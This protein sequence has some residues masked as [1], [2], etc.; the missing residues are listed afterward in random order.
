MRAAWRRRCAAGLLLWGARGQLCFFFFF[1]LCCAPVLCQA[2]TS[3]FLLLRANAR[4]TPQS[5]AY[6]ASDSPEDVKASPL[7]RA[8]RDKRVDMV[9]NLGPSKLSTNPRGN[10]LVRRTAVDHAIPLLT[11]IKLAALLADAL[12]RHSKTPMIG[13]QPQQL[14]E[15]YKSEKESEAWTSPT[16]FH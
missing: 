6:P 3:A 14:F 7:L 9:I 15:Y 16:E 11:N 12:E 8:I 2:H 5:L 13:L 1:L 10:F 4:P